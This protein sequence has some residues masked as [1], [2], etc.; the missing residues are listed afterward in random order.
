MDLDWSDNT[1]LKI[2]STKLDFNCAI[3][4]SNTLVTR[5]LNSNK[6]SFFVYQ[7]IN[8]SP[9]FAGADRQIGSLYVPHG[10]GLSLFYQ[11]KASK[12]AFARPRPYVARGPY[13]TP[14]SLNAIH[15]CQHSLK[16][17]SSSLMII[18]NCHL[19]PY[20]RPTNFQ[21]L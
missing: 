16:R 11:L 21:G 20:P 4:S 8:H 1:G 7:W 9:F 12:Q 17:L 2:Q 13:I 3:Q 18:D 10:S 15:L 6:F 19:I 5:E 14:S